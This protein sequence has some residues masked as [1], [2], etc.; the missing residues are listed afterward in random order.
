MVDQVDHLVLDHFPNKLKM[1]INVHLY[2]LYEMEDI[3][4]HHDQQKQYD[5]HQL[6]NKKL[7]IKY[8]NI[9]FLILYYV[10]DNEDKQ[11]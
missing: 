5:H 7:N 8:E 3:V 11:L 4:H 6:Q 1:L 10:D 2:L 9:F